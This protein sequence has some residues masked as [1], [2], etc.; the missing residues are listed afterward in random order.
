M[1]REQALENALLLA[2]PYVDAI[3]GTQPNTPTRLAKRETALK[4]GVEI[5]DA[6]ALPP[7][8]VNAE[9]LAALTVL[10][11]MMPLPGRFYPEEYG[12]EWEMAMD[13][14]KA[15]LARASHIPMPSKTFNPPAQA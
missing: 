4:I 10:Y 1:T 7:D 15:V 2:M 5:R 6:L 14:A 12:A 13:N 3:G 11:E 8:G 9:M